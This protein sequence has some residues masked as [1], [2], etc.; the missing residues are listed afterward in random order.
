[1]NY[2]LI[3]NDDDDYN[4]YTKKFSIVFNSTILLKQQNKTIITSSFKPMNTNKTTYFSYIVA[5]SFIGV[6]N[7]STRRNP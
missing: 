5:V 2:F 3:I 7:Q 1:M 4:F 6:G